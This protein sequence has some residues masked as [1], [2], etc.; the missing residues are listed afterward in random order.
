MK[1]FKRFFSL[2]LALILLFTGVEVPISPSAAMAEGVPSAGT[3]SVPVTPEN[4]LSA[5][6]WLYWIEDGVA[7]IAGYT[8]TSE[9]TLKI[10]GGLGG[11]PVVGIGQKAFQANKSLTSI[12]MHTNVTHIADDAFEGIGSLKIK[13]YNG[14]YALNYASKHNYVSENLSSAAVFV[15]SVLDLTGLS[16]TKIYSGLS[17]SGVIFVA[18]E[19]S[20]L[21]IG[22]ILYFPA[23]SNYPTGLAKTVSGISKNHDKYIVS[24]SQ[25][26]WGE[27]F[28]EVQGTDFLI[29]DWK[30]MIVDD[31]ITLESF[32][33]SSASE[34]SS[35]FEIGAE[36]GDW[37][38]TGK[39]DISV[40][41]PTVDYKIGSQKWGFIPIPDIEF[42][43]ARLPFVFE[44]SIEVE[45]K[46]DGRNKDA[47]EGRGYQIYKKP[48]KIDI[49][50]G[51]VPIASIAGVINGYMQLT[52][53]CEISAT[54][55]VKWKI[56]HTEII[57]YQND[58]ISHREEKSVTPTKFELEGNFK[59]GPRLKGYFVLGWG[60][61]SI[62]FFEISIGVFVSVTV[63]VARE[64]CTGVLDHLWHGGFKIEFEIPLEV[65]IGIISLGDDW[66]IGI[67]EKLQQTAGPWLLFSGHLD[68]GE[69][70]YF[71]GNFLW[72]N[73]KNCVMDKRKV[74]IENNGQ[75]VQQ[76]EYKVNEVISMPPTP[77]RPGYKFDGWYVNTLKSG[78]SGKDYLFN[79]AKDLMPYLKAE[80]TLYIYAK[81]SQMAAAV[82]PTPSPV[83]PAPST[84]APTLKPNDPTAV[85]NTPT[86]KPDDPTTVPN[87]PSPNTPT[88]KPD[89]P[90][91]APVTPEP[92]S[93]PAP[94]STPVP[95]VHV[96]RIKLNKT[97]IELHNDDAS[98]I[99]R[100]TAQVYPSNASDSSVDWESS[101]PSVAFVNDRGE[102]SVGKPGT[103][104]ITCRSVSDPDVEATC[105]VHVLQHVQQ[106]YID[107]DRDSLL[108]GE[109]VQL[110]TD[111]YPSY[112]D[113]T[114]VSW[115]SSDTGVATVNQNGLVTAVGYGDVVIT[116]T[117]EDGSDL[118]ADFPIHVEHE[119]ALEVSIVN[120]TA[121]VQSDDEVC[122]AYISPTSGSM[123]RMAQ[124]GLDLQW[125][126]S[127]KNGSAIAELNEMDTSVTK[128][129]ETYN[130]SFVALMGTDF[131]S[132]GT[133]VFTV[134]CTAGSYT[135]SV[136]V[137]VYADGTVY[138]GTVKLN[139]S[140]FY[141]NMNEA[142]T[143]PSQP[144]SADGKPVP[145]GM[146]MNIVGDGYYDDSASEIDASNGMQVSFD[147]SGVYTAKVRYSKGNL[148]YEVPVTF[149]VQDENGIIH[150][151]VEGITLNESFIQLVQ[152]QNQKLTA[153]ITPND[154][155]NK[156]VRWTS[157]DPTIAT[158][159]SDG[160]VTAKNPGAAAI[161]CEAVDGSGIVGMC[162]IAVESYLQ[163]D[164]NEVEYTIYQNAEDHTD[165]GIIN[166]THA[167]Q[168][169]LLA[170]NQN[171][172]WQLVRNTGS[173]TEIAL[174]EFR[175]SA[176]SGVSVTGNVIKL[177]RI[178][179]AGDDEYTLT[180]TAGDYSDQCRVRIHVCDM[181]LPTS[182][183][184][185]K[186]A[187]SGTVNEY[188]S[189]DI[190]PVCNPAATDL[191]E[192]TIVSVEGN[193]VFMDALSSMYSI[194]EPSELIFEKAGTYQA[195]VV[196]SGDNYAYK[197]PITITVKDK[198]GSVPANITDI[199][200]SPEYLTMLVGESVNLT[201]NVI[202]AN[203]S[204]SNLTWS[205]SDTSIVSV[206]A[207]GVV[208]AVGAGV[209]T[210]LVTAPETDI[211]GGIL[212]VVEDGLTLEKNEVVRTVFVDGTTR[213]QLDTLM[214]T[215]AS[216]SRQSS[217][218]EWNLARMS[219]NNLTL[220]VEPYQTINANG[221][222][223]YGCNI[224]L[225]S[226]S[227]VGDTIYELTCSNGNET[228]TATITIHAEER[229]S[230]LPAGIEL[231]NDTFTSDVNE[232]IVITPDYVCYPTDTNVPDGMKVSMEG[233]RQFTAAINAKDYFVSQSQT[234]LSFTKAGTYH[235]NYVME[236]GNVRYVIPL[237]F[238]VRNGSGEVPV[239]ASEI[240]LNHV[241]LN[242]VA[243][244][245]VQL[246][247]VFTPVDTTN[248][249]VTWRSSDA[250][251]VTVDAT[252][253]LRALTNGS[254]T[255]TCTPE[256]SELS[257]VTCA[258]TVEDYLTV[259]PGN[260]SMVLYMQGDQVNA[261]ATAML[262]VGTIERLENAGLT[263]QWDVNMNKV[264]HARLVAEAVYDAS[265]VNV[266]SS[267]LLSAGTDTYVVKC[268]A[269]NYTW[270]Q[271]YTLIV[272]S[273]GSNAP[274]AVSMRTPTVNASVNQSVTIDFSPVLTPANAQL[275][276]SMRSTYVGLGD[277]YDARDEASYVADGD[278]VTVKF[279][280]AGQY[281]LTRRYRLGNMQFVVPCVIKVGGA[282]G[283]FNLLTATETDFTV[284][285]G[286]KSGSVSNI[287]L[288]DH[289]VE[290]LWGDSIEWSVQR[291]SGNSLNVAL[292]NNGS[293]VDVFVA[294]AEKNG[295]DVWRVT[296]K[297]GGLS[298]SVDIQLMA[299]DP[300]GALPDALV[301]AEDTI[302][303]VIGTWINVP[304]SFACVPSGTM[305]PDQGD[306]F[307]S[308][309]MDAHGTDRSVIRIENG[310]AR[311]SFV[312][313]GYYT[314]DLKYTSGNVN[315]TVPVYFVISDEE[316]VVSRPALQIFLINASSVVYPEGE[317]NVP[318]AQAA[319]SETL[320]VS[321]IGASLAYMNT[322]EAEW[323]V[324]INS[325]TAATLSLVQSSANIYDLVLTGIKAP[326]DITYTVSCKV[327]GA[328]YSGNGTLHVASG[329]EERPDPTLSRTSYQVVQGE[330]VVID[331]NLYSKKDGSILQS[332]STWNP[333]T[334]L[335]AAGYEVVE[336]ENNWL[337]TFYKAGT[338]TTTVDGYA[339]NLKVQVPLSIQVIPAGGM[340][341]MSVMRLPVALTEIEEE[342]FRGITTNVVDL[343]GTKVETIGSAAF[344]DCVDLLEI[345]LPSTVKNIADN[346]FYGCLNVTFHCPSG[347]YAEFYAIA[348]GFDVIN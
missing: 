98:A 340:A 82:T 212:V 333:S 202:P 226:V 228:V 38:I 65:K 312:E 347:S 35:N 307:W 153:T 319:V 49:K 328:T 96:T 24:F 178:N 254:A 279:T 233:D 129:G 60:D 348:H 125:F 182:V 107:A 325:G 32:S 33:S 206:S 48:V 243:N 114:S 215:E 253:N 208:T 185:K 47:W 40:E 271:E 172:T 258:V 174:E 160:V 176:E 124:A 323:N 284:Y 17:D 8:N 130:S 299:A 163:L 288:N 4:L 2:T 9:S 55:E 204:Y 229:G 20:F 177:I 267:E 336:E 217:A 225:Y 133:S 46:N 257:P 203:A 22:Q 19:A 150:L 72:A 155:Y 94:T 85:P 45:Y 247:A 320:S 221:Q 42:V 58:K 79:F 197:C 216:S 101:N 21:S 37:S 239:Q 39:L 90:T 84:V 97:S 71:S 337:V 230:V 183:S 303:G 75:L 105:V 210:V 93:T 29:F 27:V 171:V 301:I 296:A 222:T 289:M 111:C 263:P 110:T 87:T 344:M 128:D 143:I 100:L 69:K 139:P 127:R 223:L 142:A 298:D 314:A 181:S 235:A 159:S 300:R 199:Q 131:P 291:V 343:R 146:S 305:L 192:D 274:T 119:L 76:K 117:T 345:Y 311:F 196:F 175:N 158:V 108:P 115:V 104:T 54:F 64:Q 11:Y 231:Q 126:V 14:S 302:S 132:T 341:T 123:Q 83:T 73:Y 227:R 170:D 272:R 25:P 198:T 329:T 293:S 13:A 50:L 99:T 106:I 145:A 190:T 290:T 342:A 16:S 200:V 137:S 134:T 56:V 36:M 144:T 315:Y 240:K 292:K 151:R 168:Q 327:N 234:T 265:A 81:W 321:H 201:A 249:N 285:S 283:S 331:R 113:N 135:A 324:K 295:M 89:A 306:E 214:L 280:K 260:T 10:P 112:A 51:K 294:D 3:T 30:N 219:G 23:S 41:N 232:L 317:V 18:Q 148:D 62:K 252:G 238:R 88:P 44:P 261:T 269:G 162:A 287:S 6:E 213:M 12:Q 332:S 138:A 1:K 251:V 241:N 338:F 167:S 189:V 304:L 7:Y 281:I 250:T 149:Y 282:S 330:Q 224:I 259:I 66:E 57:T 26:Q 165:L 335:A 188:I 276:S 152:G 74:I 184:L 157:S 109:T 322:Q 297:F 59:F 205:S 286:G 78:L 346:A 207:K 273:A 86:P 103:A 256:D 70:L 169:R 63:S 339:G 316:D 156:T 244:E 193:R 5:G 52:V 310:M 277:F 245:T 209:T 308:V 179:G 67:A 120:D 195:E 278:T 191:P 309:E 186:T 242:L 43:E 80:S 237:L 91:S 275:P 140:T 161:Y 102:F 53:V 147:E 248:Q 246:E 268:T 154:A 211:V 164:D 34:S 28:L 218:P 77:S 116:A 92:T 262:S 141:L 326:G 95:V 122:I 118:S 166:V 31:G 220:R 61:I 266:S 334:F 68:V 313:S 121:F 15:D 236:Y 180:C 187:Y 270:Q 318:I 136:D 255:I 173:S 264:T 194:T